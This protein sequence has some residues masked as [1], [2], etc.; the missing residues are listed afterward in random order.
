MCIIMYICMFT[1]YTLDWRFKPTLY[2][3]ALREI[4]LHT[5]L[6][7][8]IQNKEDD[9]GTQQMYVALL[10]LIIFIEIS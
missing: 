3:W 1:M 10:L 2:S 4:N 8:L 9:L 5:F 7:W 6:E